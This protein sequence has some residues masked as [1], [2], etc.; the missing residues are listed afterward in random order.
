[1]SISVGLD[2]CS[3]GMAD[4]YHTPGFIGPGHD[5]MFWRGA[6]LRWTKLTCFGSENP[7][8]P[9]IQEGNSGI[10]LPCTVCRNQVSWCMEFGWRKP[11]DSTGNGAERFGNARQS[12]QFLMSISIESRIA[13]M[14]GKKFYRKWEAAHGSVLDGFFFL[15]EKRW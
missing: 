11:S 4:C 1:M 9:F 3:C 5:C 8:G 14:T 6:K 2:A 12:A 10:S 7:R 13:A 15:F